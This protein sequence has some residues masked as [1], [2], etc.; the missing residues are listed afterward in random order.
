MSTKGL[1]LLIAA[2]SVV[3]A[4]A[5]ASVAVIIAFPKSP[6]VGASADFATTVETEP[7]GIDGGFDE[8]TLYDTAWSELN[9]AMRSGDRDAFLA[10]ADG[11]AT[12]QLADWWDHSKQLGWEYGYIQPY[13]DDDGVEQA[14]VGLELPFTAAPVRSSGRSDAGQ[15]LLHGTAYAIETT[16]E[17]AD[18]KITSF[19]PI[20][21]AN[22]WDVGALY[23]Q[24]RD[25]VVLFGLE[26][27]QAL[28]DANIDAAED[29]AKL[30][31]DTAEQLGAEVPQD[32][33]VTAITGDPERFTEWAFGPTEPAVVKAAAV[34]RPT[35]RPSMPS[36][37]L[38]PSIATGRENSGSYVVMGPG[39]ADQLKQTFV[40]EFAHVL[41]FSAVPDSGVFR[42][43][44]VLEGFAR[45]METASG[46]QD[47]SLVTP[48]VQQLVAA[49]GVEALADANF[50]STDAL[51]AY[52][53]A[54]SYYQFVAESG[55]DPWAL[56]VAAKR[57]DAGL[58]VLGSLP[59]VG[60]KIDDAYSA[61]NWIAWVQ[62]R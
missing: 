59:A 43:H 22:P 47:R 25:H 24:Q 32:G 46:T 57:D 48:E 7:W 60:E 4:A 61:E 38:E 50:D 34:A 10:H 54:G 37:L 30:A 44:A 29:T 52:D 8:F 9:S 6:E 16:G 36:D 40:H 27:E 41:H 21:A 3:A 5:L 31:L 28:I 42:S 39:S 20:G 18:L 17:G 58:A 35:D 23:V 12:T 2:I 49:S 15:K 51:A 14:L 11:E 19:T 62:A 55:G 13:T 33:F 56:A 1:R 26:S 53:A 45:Y